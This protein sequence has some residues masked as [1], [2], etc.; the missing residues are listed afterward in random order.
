MKYRSRKHIN[1][2]EKYMFVLIIGLLLFILIGKSSRNLRHDYKKLSIAILSRSRH[3]AF[4]L[5]EVVSALNYNDVH[6]FNSDE[7]HVDLKNKFVKQ[8]YIH[9]IYNGEYS[10]YLPFYVKTDAHTTHR[11]DKEIGND[12]EERLKWW[13]G[14]NMDFLKMLRFMRDKHRSKYYLF[15]EDD[16]VFNG[17]DISEIIMDGEP[18]VHLGEGAGAILMTD[19]FTESLIGYLMLRTNALPLDWLIEMFISSIGR[20]LVHNKV[21]THV[22][23]VST[24]PK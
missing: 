5:N 6:V 10:N 20:K 18:V 11:Y 1:I 13:K 16:N 17:N 3:D 22:G 4:Y 2:R 19:E 14:Q 21:F 8:A 9:K 24:K 15:L 7:N 12:L 23:N